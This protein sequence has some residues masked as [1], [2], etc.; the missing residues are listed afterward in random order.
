MF[1]RRRGITISNLP[2]YLAK[3]YG[4]GEGAN[5]QPMIHVQD[6]PSRGWRYREIGIK[7]GRQHDYLSSPE[8]KYHYI[9]D[10]SVVVLDI[11]EQFPLLPV[12]RTLEIAEL[13]GIPH[14]MDTV[15][16]E[17][18]VMTTDFLIKVRQPIGSIE[19][20]RTIKLAK[21][22]DN[23]RTIEKFEIERRFWRARGIDWGIVTENEI[24]EDLVENVKW[25]H[26]YTTLSSVAPLTREDVCLIGAELTRRVNRSK[27]CLND[28]TTQC[29]T[30]FRLEVGQSL[31]IARH[32]IASRQWIVDMSKPIHPSQKLTLISHSFA[33]V[34]QKQ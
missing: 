17:P 2:K 33:G 24:N 21:D 31:V 3:G 12:E 14:P 13:C 28:L 4:Q 1:R 30:M 23:K 20:A 18:F 9:V 29:D 7:T 34:K 26:K 27:A 10:G 22:L 11:R 5:Y 6:F 19:L 16:R 25:L 15:T 32:L 8:L